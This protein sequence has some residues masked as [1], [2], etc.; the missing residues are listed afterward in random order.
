MWTKE[1]RGEINRIRNS[2]ELMRDPM[3]CSS[4]AWRTSRQWAKDGY[5]L[6]EGAVGIRGYLNSTMQE[7]CVRYHRLEVY[8]AGRNGK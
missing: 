7:R 1:I 6:K 5:R 8:K 4:F 2:K 3:F